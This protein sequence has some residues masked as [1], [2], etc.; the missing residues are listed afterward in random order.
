MHDINN[1]RE[2]ESYRIHAKSIKN[3][4]DFK[5]I[6][7]IIT[8]KISELDEF[9]SA[10]TVMSYLSKDDEVSLESLFIDKTK[11]WFV[12]LMKNSSIV[13][14]PYKYRE[15]ILRK[16]AFGIMEPEVKPDECFDQVQK[17]I[18][19]DLIL[20]P[21]LC[22]DKKGGRIGYGG[23]YYDKFLKL[24]PGSKK[25]GCCPKDCLYDE[26]PQDKWDIRVDLVVF[27]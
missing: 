10:K 14:A 3:R 13:L 5:K 19:I 20:V 25:I 1:T 26:L 2:K 8:H 23:G 6:S 21:G 11:K 4:V 17:K 15:T 9:K 22:F 12:P 18:P 27:D 7:Q 24:N 16:G